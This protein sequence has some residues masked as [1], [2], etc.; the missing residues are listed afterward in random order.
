[1]RRT[2]FRQRRHASG[3]ALLRR[4]G[5]DATLLD[6]RGNIFL[7]VLGTN[8]RLGPTLELCNHLSV[9][10]DAGPG[11]LVHYA[12]L[13]VALITHAYNEHERQLF[14]GRQVAVLTELG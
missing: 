6:G 11:G 2:R 5:A 8:P 7:N 3:A 13:F 10:V 12:D 1:M 4:I 9:H 14:E